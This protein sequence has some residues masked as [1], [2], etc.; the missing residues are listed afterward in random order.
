[1]RPEARRTGGKV[2]KVMR[3]FRSGSLRSSSGQKVTNP[4]Q[5]V[6]I[7][8][9]E[10]RR[11]KKYA[12][13]GVTVEEAA[14][15]RRLEESAAKARREAARMESPMPTSPERLRMQQQAEEM[16]RRGAEARAYEESKRPYVPGNARGGAIAKQNT[17]HGKVDMPFKSLNKFAG[18]KQG[19]RVDPKGMMK[20]EVAFM[21]AKGAPKSM[22]KHEMGEMKAAKYAR[23]GGIESRG[24][25]KG[26]VIK[27]ASGGSVRGGGC[28][29]RGKTR[30][31]MV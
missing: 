7:G 9:S 23:G 24:N 31:K 16:K 17:A 29:T 14:E 28:E 12:G 1:M 21:K 3:E 19:G 10:Q 15:R 20:K 22:L 8:L 11:M 2:E 13:G 30:G 26:T 25:T 18:M 4:K 5:A 6:A 27:M